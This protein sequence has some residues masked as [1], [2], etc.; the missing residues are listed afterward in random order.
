M[1]KVFSL[2]CFLCL[3]RRALPYANIYQGVALIELKR[4]SNKF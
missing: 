2:E 1:Y 3:E 4:K